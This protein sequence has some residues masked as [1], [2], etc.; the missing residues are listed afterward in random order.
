MAEPSTR[1]EPQTMEPSGLSLICLL[2]PMTQPKSS[3]STPAAVSAVSLRR[4]GAPAIY[5][6]SARKALPILV[7]VLAYV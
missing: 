6:S 7:A 1:M 4:N 2:S 3:V 5:D